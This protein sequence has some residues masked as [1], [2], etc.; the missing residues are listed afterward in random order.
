MP[1]S[2]HWNVGDLTS[3]YSLAVILK[4]RPFVHVNT[5]MVVKLLIPVDPKES[6]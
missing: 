5:L 3:S 6:F 2:L 1:C 4:Y